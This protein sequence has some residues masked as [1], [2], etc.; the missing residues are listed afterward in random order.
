MSKILS[1]NWVEKAEQR[2]N[3]NAKLQPYRDIIMYDW[4]DPEH[5]HW[6]ATAPISEIVSWAE[7]VTPDEMDNT[8]D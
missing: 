5:Y 4:N 8:D 7:V 2:I 6:A 1:T 3:R